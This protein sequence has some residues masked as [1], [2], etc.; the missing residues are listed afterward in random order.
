MGV[1]PVWTGGLP[2][3]GAWAAALADHGARLDVTSAQRVHQ[4]ECV[5]DA[6]GA[7]LGDRLQRVA[8]EPLGEDLDLADARPDVEVRA[9]RGERGRAADV[10]VVLREARLHLGDHVAHVGLGGRVL[11]LQALAEEG[12]QGDGG[13]DPDDQDHDQQLDQGE[14]ALIGAEAAALSGDV[15]CHGV[16][17]RGA[18]RCRR[19][20]GPRTARPWSNGVAGCAYY[21]LAPLQPPPEGAQVRASGVPE[22]CVIVKVRVPP[23]DFE[24]ATMV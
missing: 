10:L 2:V 6:A 16:S 3:A 14:A 24:V 17:L 18:G 20:G 8:R 13:E 21:Q 19:S 23:L 12:R 9:R 5:V 22:A 4:R 7:G 1:Y 15:P 11:A